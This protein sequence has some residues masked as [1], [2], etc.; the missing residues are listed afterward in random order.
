MK[1][2]TVR[3]KIEEVMKAAFRS[4][5]VHEFSSVFLAMPVDGLSGG[6]IVDGRF[7]IGASEQTIGRQLRKMRELGIVTATRRD[8][9]TFKEYALAIRAPIQQ[10]MALELR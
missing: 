1:K 6:R 9:K 7:Y 8:G 2:K 5:A 4:L 3:Q 10:E